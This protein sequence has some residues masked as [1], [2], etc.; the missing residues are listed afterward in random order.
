MR[1]YGCIYK[2]HTQETQ[3]ITHMLI[4]CAVRSN[5]RRYH[6]RG[7]AWLFEA[8]ARNCGGLNK[9]GTWLNGVIVSRLGVGYVTKSPSGA[10][11]ASR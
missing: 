9:H 6:G 8:D 2:L 11:L 5:S 3:G 1:T 4:Y 7:S 10:K